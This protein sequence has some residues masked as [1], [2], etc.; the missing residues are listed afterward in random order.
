MYVSY[1]KFPVVHFQAE[2]CISSQVI[3]DVYTTDNFTNLWMQSLS[4]QMP[5]LNF[6]FED[7]K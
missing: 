3:T 5:Q 7:Y 1:I 6:G 4:E 2:M